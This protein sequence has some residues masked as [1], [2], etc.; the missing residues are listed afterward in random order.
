MSHNAFGHLFRFTTFGE[1]H[2]PLIGCVVDGCPPLLELTEADI[3]TYLDKRRPGQSRFTTQR[4]EPDQVKILSGVFEDDRTGGPVTT[5]TPIMLMIENVDQRS[6]DYAEIRDKFRPGHADL[7]YQAKYGIRDYKGGGRSSARETAARVAAGA[8]AR[9]IIPGVTIRGALI[10]MGPHKID[11][12]N[13]DWGQV[14]RNPFFCPDAKAAKFYED[15]LDGVRKS[16]SSIGAIIE[17]TASG[18]PSGWGAPLYGKLDQDLASAMMSINAAKGF[19]VGSGFASTRTM[20]S[21]QNDRF[22]AETDPAGHPK[23]R[24]LTNNSGG[25]QGGISNGSDIVF[26]V[27]F[28]PVSTIS[29]AQETA[30]KTGNPTILENKGRHDPCVLPRA[31][32]IVE[33]MCALV[34]ADHWLLQKSILL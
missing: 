9:K 21:E 7:T 2:G 11:R 8:V 4:Q 22:A 24:T 15:Y 17:V 34:L 19:E 16:G 28:K 32:P 30:D 18:V 29:S 27:A 6:K 10:Q 14:D 31:V 13:W 33:S 23:F 12:T 3:Q 26:R 20:G 25:I 5:G 1:S